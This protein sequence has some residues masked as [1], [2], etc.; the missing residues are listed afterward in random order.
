MD[1]AAAVAF[2]G[3]TGVH[4]SNIDASRK[5]MEN[6]ITRRTEEGQLEQAAAGP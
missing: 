1:Y 5:L 4:V 2:L 3:S 6:E